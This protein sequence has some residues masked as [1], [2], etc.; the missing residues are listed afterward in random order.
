MEAHPQ[1]IHRYLY[2]ISLCSFE[3]VSFL[4]LVV[5]LSIPPLCLSSSRFYSMFLK[6]MQSIRDGFQVVSINNSK[7]VQ[8]EKSDFQ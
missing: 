3:I 2:I 6:V 1:Q 8:H 4:F 5:Y 7:Y